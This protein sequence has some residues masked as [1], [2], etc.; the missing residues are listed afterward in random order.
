MNLI[1]LFLLFSL[2]YSASVPL[3]S[4]YQDLAI[5]GT[6]TGVWSLK[7]ILPSLGV[8]ETLVSN[9]SAAYY[10]D[11][12]NNRF[13]VK[14]GTVGGDQYTTNNGTWMNYGYGC[15][16]YPYTYTYEKT[17]G[18]TLAVKTISLPLGFDFY[19]GSVRDPGEGTGLIAFTATLNTNTGFPIEST[20]N[21]KAPTV[22]VNGTCPANPNYPVIIDGIIIFTNCVAGVP[23]PSHFVMPS[24]CNATSQCWAA[25]CENPYNCF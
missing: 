16:Q 24:V 10:N 17:V 5:S 6:C 3:G 4:P 7:L 1:P 13:A 14:L 25:P 8:V 20:F 15:F 23:D 18:K 12:P 9:Q 2:A 11:V 22:I 21:Q 19:S